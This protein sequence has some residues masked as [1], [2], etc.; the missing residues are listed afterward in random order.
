[1]K[2]KY[3]YL[4]VIKDTYTSQRVKKNNK[5]ID[6]MDIFVKSNWYYQYKIWLILRCVTP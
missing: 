2:F 1:M 6:S 3:I 5:L 4:G